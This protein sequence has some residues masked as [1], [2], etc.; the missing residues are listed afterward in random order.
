MMGLSGIRRAAIV[1]PHPDDEVL[2]CG[3]TI[4][5]LARQGTEVHVIIVTR[6]QEPQFSSAYVDQVMAEARAAHQRLGVH[7]THCLDLPAAALDTVSVAD[8]NAK[9]GSKL[10]EI[11]PDVLFV[12]FLGDIHVDHQT[13]FSASMVWARPRGPEVPAHVLAYETLSETN[14]YAPQVTP[15]FSPNLFVDVEG[16]LDDKLEAF[17]LYS[18]QVKNFPDERSLEAIRA[19]AQLRGATAHCRAAEAFVTVRSILRWQ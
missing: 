9:I 8:I 10:S 2:G 6:G 3:A 4:A 17:S 12:P 1:A 19:L 5:R 7:A 11:I 18:S 14:W 16:F 13:A 15:A